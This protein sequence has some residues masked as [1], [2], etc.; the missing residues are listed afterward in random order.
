MNFLPTEEKSIIDEAEVFI[1]KVVEREERVSYALSLWKVCFISED[2]YC[3]QVAERLLVQHPS[4]VFM[5]GQKVKSIVNMSVEAEDQ[6]ML[7]RLL[8]LLLR[9][10][11]Q[12]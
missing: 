1:N 10:D 8:Q 9:H 12:Q 7:N 2:N 4:L 3:Q 11:L 5:I 6:E